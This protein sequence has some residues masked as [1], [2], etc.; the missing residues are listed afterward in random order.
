MGASL[1]DL[2]IRDVQEEGKAGYNRIMNTMSKQGNLNRGYQ[3]DLSNGMKKNMAT[4]DV[5][6]RG[7]WV[8]MTSQEKQE[9]AYQKTYG[10]H[11]GSYIDRLRSEQQSRFGSVM[12]EG[13]PDNGIT[14]NAKG[15]YVDKRPDGSTVFYDDYGAKTDAN[16]NRIG[17]SYHHDGKGTFTSNRVAA[18]T[19]EEGHASSNGTSQNAVFNPITGAGSGGGYTNQANMSPVPNQTNPM[20]GGPVV[21]PQFD[22]SHGNTPYERNRQVIKKKTRGYQNTWV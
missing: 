18:S 5:T 22:A 16:G 8:P 21:T 10:N 3:Y 9:V 17:G 7:K 12:R 20:T 14:K 2:G 13:G 4:S 6:V 19:N 11:P 1:E 15:V